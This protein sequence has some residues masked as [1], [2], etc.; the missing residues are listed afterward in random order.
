M[1][2]PINHINLGHI[3]P[4]IINAPIAITEEDNFIIIK[5]LDEFFKFPNVLLVN[6]YRTEVEDFIT[7]IPNASF[8]S[9]KQMD[10]IWSHK[11]EIERVIGKDLLIMRRWSNHGA[12]W[13]NRETP[14]SR[15]AYNDLWYSRP[16]LQR[17]GS[18]HKFLFVINLN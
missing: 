11:E 9:E 4:D 6:G 7:C 15:I 8:P 12:I 17:S 13:L 18:S 2:Y 3:K 14:K 16:K 10:I 1:S 5:C